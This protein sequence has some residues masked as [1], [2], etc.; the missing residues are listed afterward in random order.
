[1]AHKPPQQPRI[2]NKFLWYSDL[3]PGVRKW[4]WL[5][6]NWGINTECSCEHEGYIQ[7]QSLDPT[8][9]IDNIRRCLFEAGLY[10]Y[11]ITVTHDQMG[12]SSGDWHQTLE[13]KSPMFIRR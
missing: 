13:I 10:N 3:E 5:L 12:Q 4:I 11:T 7:C 8:T 1:M 9:E 2:Q 6:R